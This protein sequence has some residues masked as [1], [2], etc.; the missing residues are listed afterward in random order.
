MGGEEV[1]MRAAQTEL[2][3]CVCEGQDGGRAH[4]EAHHEAPHTDLLSLPSLS[5]QD[6]Q[7]DR[8]RIY[9]QQETAQQAQHQ[10]EQ[11][12]DRGM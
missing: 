5:C 3:S 7:S 2:P 8:P 4:H 11:Q 1:R 6:R 12:Q 9:L 10:R